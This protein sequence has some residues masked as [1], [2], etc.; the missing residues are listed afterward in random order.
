M[1]CAAVRLGDAGRVPDAPTDRACL[2]LCTH[3]SV[4]TIRVPD[5]REQAEYRV[6]KILAAPTR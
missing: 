3:S 6:G 1:T 5:M 2:G 4:R